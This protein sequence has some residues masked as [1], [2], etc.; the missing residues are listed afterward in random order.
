MLTFTILVLAGCGGNSA[1]DTS[2]KGGSAEEPINLT[3]SHFWPAAH[4]IETKVVKGWIEE[5]EKATDGKVR[6]TSYPAGTLVPANETYD[7]VT[8]GVADIGISA[9]AYTRGRFPVVES[10]LLPGLAYNNSTA[11]SVALQ[12]GIERSF[13]QEAD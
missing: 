10:F 2:G 8:K 1:K 6:I 7:S 9:Y 4:E 5:V 13:Y 12:E 3:L 11:A